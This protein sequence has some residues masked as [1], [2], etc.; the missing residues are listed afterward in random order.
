M[1]F[2]LIVFAILALLFTFL[3]MQQKASLESFASFAAQQGAE[4]WL[5]S[6]RSMENGEINS[7]RAEDPIGYRIFDNLLLSSTTYEGHFEEM[8]A[9]GGKTGMVFRMDT[10]DD[11]SGQKAALIGNALGKRLGSPILKPESTKVSIT[12]NNNALR[13]RLIVEI[14]QEVKVPL[15]GIKE[16]FGG[17]DTLTLNARS[18][19]A[20]TEP[21]EYIR[22][23]DLAVELSRRFGEEIDLKD[24]TEKIKAKGKGE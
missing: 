14:T 5:D 2:I 8:A 23:F 4:L 20:V 17:K 18:E 19:A 9:V 15:G 3:Y 22:N 10:G 7:E 13:E 24:L 21:D 16:F 12:F 11:L 6:R 1:V